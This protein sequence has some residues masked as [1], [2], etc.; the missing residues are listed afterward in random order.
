[1][2]W[3]R[4]P[5]GLER[6]VSTCDDSP[7]RSGHCERGQHWGMVSVA[8]LWSGGSNAEKFEEWSRCKRVIGIGG[9]I[10]CGRPH[11][12]SIVGC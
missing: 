6:G 4:T 11:Q 5:F 12:P 9:F 10:S 7:D 3:V 2:A 1:M 8:E